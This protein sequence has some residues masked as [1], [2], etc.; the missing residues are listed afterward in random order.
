MTCTYSFAQEERC[1]WDAIVVHQYASLA[2][3]CTVVFMSTVLLH[4]LQYFSLNA[5]AA[6]RLLFDESSGGSSRVSVAKVEDIVPGV[7]K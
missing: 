3:L 2:Y 1:G 6:R 5:S 7:W 4:M